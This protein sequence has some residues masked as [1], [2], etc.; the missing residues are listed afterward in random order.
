MQDKHYNCL[1]VS[2]KWHKYK[3]EYQLNIR[4][5]TTNVN[6]KLIK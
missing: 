1:H 2:R 5:Q 3:I 6:K 4:S